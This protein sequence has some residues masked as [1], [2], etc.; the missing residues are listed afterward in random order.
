MTNV[1]RNVDSRNGSRVDI[2]ISTNAVAAF[3]WL[4]VINIPG[5]FSNN[6]FILVNKVKTVTFQGDTSVDIED[7][8]NVLTIKSLGS[9]SR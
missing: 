3:V 5:H 7:F 2:T 1:K 6:G 9:V 8:K 4:D